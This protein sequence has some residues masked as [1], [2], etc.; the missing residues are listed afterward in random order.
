MANISVKKIREIVHYREM[1]ISER[2]T[3]ALTFTSK[4]SVGRIWKRAKDNGWLTETLRFLTDDE[5]NQLFYPKIEK[6]DTSKAVPDFQKIH[7]N[8]TK[9]QN[10]SLFHEW[11]NFRKENPDTYSYQWTT[12]LYNRWCSVHHV[13]PVLL[14]NEPPGECMYVDWAGRKLNFQFDG[15]SKTTE[16]HFFV[17]TIGASQLPYVEPTLDEKQE[18]M[19][20]CHINAMHYY[21]GVPKYMIPDNLT[22]AIKKHRDRELEIQ[23]LYEDLQDFYGYVVLP[24][25]KS[26]PTDK[27]DV[28]NQVRISYD[29]ILSELEEHAGEYHNLKDVQNA[30]RHYLDELC[31]HEFRSTG[32]SRKEWFNTTDKPE[33]RALPKKD[34]NIYA[35]EYTLVGQDYHVHIKGD[36]HKYSVPYQYIGKNVMIKYTHTQLR[37]F[38][39]SRELIAEWQ[40]S[41]DLTL[42]N[43]HTNDNHRPVAHQIA[44]AS[45]TRDKAW[46][47]HKAGEVGPNTALYIKTYMS[48]Y[49]NPEQSYEGCMGIITMTWS[50]RKNRVS[51]E[52]MEQICKEGMELRVYNY[53]FVK[54]RVANLNKQQTSRTAERLI[55]NPVNLRGK[56]NY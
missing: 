45:K 5:V 7:S 11:Y 19:I 15:D 55:D 53:G 48:Q 50:S 8:L 23:S 27:N 2:E 28:E 41:H 22:T 12:V 49:K 44:V 6:R 37:I 42:N 18:T 56:G 36:N 43:V 51:R 13:K 40:R 30:A 46:I 33:L 39:M 34:F 26:S 31:E 47:L 25:R 21:G 16:M 4:G 35:Y 54:N 32:L 24:A 29:W 14:M 52:L 20:Q 10:R 3:A 17:S 38:T 9:F 1:N